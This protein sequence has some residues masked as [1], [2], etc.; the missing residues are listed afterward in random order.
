MKKKKDRKVK[1]EFEQKR[2]LK[3]IMI[4]MI[5]FIITICVLYNVL[6]LINTTI[7]QKDYFHV[8]GISFFSVKTDLMENDL[9]KNDFVIVK[10]VTDSDLQVG[11]IIT[12]EVNDQIRINKI[13]DEKDGYI[14]KSNKNYYP[15]IEKI[16]INQILGKK[17]VSIP[18]LGILLYLLQSKIFSV[19]VLLFLIFVFWYNKY[20]HTKRKERERKKKKSENNIRGKL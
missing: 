16:T 5:S 15:D 10:E 19:F 9:H 14:T 4:A 1:I 7:S 17:V 11:D 18:F 8:F 2:K 3:K 6:F 20:T 13:V 12:Y